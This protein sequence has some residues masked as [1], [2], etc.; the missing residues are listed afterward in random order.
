MNFASSRPDRP[1]SGPTGQTHVLSRLVVFRADASNRLGGGHVMRCLC[2]A[3][4]LAALGWTIAF[5]TLAESAVVV[6]C[7]RAKAQLFEAAA[8]AQLDPGALARR[9]PEGCDLLVVD[10]YDLDETFES[11]CRGWARHVTVIDDLADRRHDCD[12]LVDM[13][14]GRTATDYAALVPAW[15]TVLAGSSYTLLRPEFA[16]LRPCAIERRALAASGTR[17]LVSLGLT[18]LGEASEKVMR[19]LLAVPSIAAV[20][21]VVG[22]AADSVGRLALLA[23]ED[24]RATL[25]VD[26]PN[27]ATLMVEADLAIGAGGTTSWERCCLGLPTV[28][29]VL[30]ENQ[31]LVGRRLR[32]VGAA[33][34]VS[35]FDMAAFAGHV[36][37]LLNDA[38]RRARMSAAAAAIADGQGAER[39]AS[40]M[41][42][43]GAAGSE[44]VRLRLADARDSAALWTWRNDPASRAAFRDGRPVSWDDHRNWF[45]E[46]VENSTRSMLIGIVGREAIGVVR[47]D[48]PPGGSLEVS[49]NVS[50]EWRGMGLGLKL[51]AAACAWADETV[52]GAALHAE[53]RSENEA[54]QRVFAACGFGFASQSDGYVRGHRPPLGRS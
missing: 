12:V 51:L 40:V 18:D 25:Y 39:V 17:V 43:L 16:A 34:E 41:V 32:E 8:S 27:V 48:G 19:A 26:P 22:S 2:L 20:D 1:C 7:L 6:P 30:T 14:F 49:I 24:A 10:H 28:L 44:D 9:W 3:E 45:A 11:A 21:V 42:A 46:S 23:A 35:L 54:S 5:A 4:R 31:R 37:D 53:I 33:V 47:F 29:L 13:T 38:P 52:G 50:P 15:A 36:V